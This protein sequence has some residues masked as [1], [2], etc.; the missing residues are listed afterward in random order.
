MDMTRMMS[1]NGMSM[2]NVQEI[3]TEET[4]SNVEMTKYVVSSLVL[5]IHL[6]VNMIHGRKNANLTSE[7]L[8]EVKAKEFL[9]KTL[10]LGCTREIKRNQ[11]TLI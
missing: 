5:R 1:I 7:R 3:N 11:M 2:L 8:A 10:R 9:S 4:G 6:N